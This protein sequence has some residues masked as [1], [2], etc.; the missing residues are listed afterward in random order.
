MPASM[1]SGL[2]NFIAELVT[3][4]TYVAINT[5]A[6]VSK[7]IGIRNGKEW[8]V[9]KI[10]LTESLLLTHEEIKALG[11][12]LRRVTSLSLSERAGRGPD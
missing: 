7:C 9:L 12:G 11:G 4:T 5:G 2:M 10:L 3:M 6:K 8:A 1:L